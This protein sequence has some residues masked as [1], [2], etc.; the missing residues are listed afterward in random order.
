MKTSREEGRA[1]RVLVAG[2]GLVVQRIGDRWRGPGTHWSTL[3]LF[4]DVL[5]TPRLAA[6]AVVPGSTRQRNSC[7][8]LLPPDL[9]LHVLNRLRHERVG[10]LIEA[11]AVHARLLHGAQG[12]HV[13][14]RAAAVVGGTYVA[15]LRV[16]PG[17]SV[18][19]SLHGDWGRILDEYAERASGPL[20]RTYYLAA[21]RYARMMVRRAIWGADTRLWWVSGWAGSMAAPEPRARS[22]RTRPIEATRSG[23]FARSFVQRDS[24]CCL[25]ASSPRP[26]A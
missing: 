3:G 15:A 19:V 12:R 18:L 25:W 20:T 5:A 16:A 17:T 1:K 9:D 22:I 21:A 23:P 4:L 13:C 14:L 8:T 7:D 26:R 24:G 2:N 10:R 6:I 11:P